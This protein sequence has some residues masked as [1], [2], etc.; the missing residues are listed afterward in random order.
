LE[1]AGYEGAV[2]AEARFQDILQAVAAWFFPHRPPPPP[3]A[4]T[5]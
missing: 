1:L 2:N 5:R 4:G 3:S